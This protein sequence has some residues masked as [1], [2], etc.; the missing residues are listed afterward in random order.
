MTPRTPSPLHLN[1]S[2]AVCLGCVLLLALFRAAPAQAQLYLLPAEGNDLVGS[3]SY[4]Q[5][6]QGDTLLDIARRYG[7]G[8]E[9]IRDANPTVDT[10]LP[11]AGTRVRLPTRFILPN[12]P[13]AGIVINVAEMRLYY[14]PKPKPGYAP[15]VDTFAISIGRG[16]WNTPEMLTQVTAKI[17][18]PAWYPPASI[19]AEHAADGKPLPMRVD[20]GE[21]NPLGK[22]A[23]SLR[24]SSYLIHGTNKDF[25]IGMQ[26]THGCIRLYPE[27]I[28]LLFNDVPKGTAVR[29]INEPYKVGWE[30]NRLYLEI[31]PLLEGTPATV[32]Q[33]RT[34]L[35]QTL[36]AA[37]AE[38][39]DY[40]I[41]WQAVQEI[42]KQQS[43]IPMPV[44]PAFSTAGTPHG[45]PD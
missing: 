3:V 11:G 37:T 30:D 18:D 40:P 13:R 41:D 6:K 35:V 43:G 14:F 20:P 16:D 5:A 44:G 7:L 27:D 19:R 31:H 45:M 26:V 28:E 8:Y 39:A 33:N 32:Q 24:N 2:F 15:M 23:L 22:Y 4:T 12:A 1:T 17:T 21:D 9:E 29:I 36:I 42:E 38:R 34:P 10:W 25:G